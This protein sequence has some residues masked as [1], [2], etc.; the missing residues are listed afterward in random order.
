MDQSRSGQRYGHFC[1]GFVIVFRPFGTRASI[2]AGLRKRSHSATTK[3][4]H[5]WMRSITQ[6]RWSFNSFLSFRVAPFEVESSPRLAPREI[7]N[8]T[9]FTRTIIS[10]SSPVIRSVCLTDSHHFFSLL[11]WWGHCVFSP[12][13]FFLS[14]QRRIPAIPPFRPISPSYRHTV[15]HTHGR[16]RRAHTFPSS[17]AAVESDFKLGRVESLEW[18]GKKKGIRWRE[19]KKKKKGKV[20]GWADLSI[21]CVHLGSTAVVECVLYNGCWKNLEQ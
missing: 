14:W 13:V 9:S 8:Q 10:F 15:T 7:R 3:D 5:I 2:S 20:I 19:G 21:L 6:H 12:F 18:Q 17:W 11:W 1:L 4:E 16:T